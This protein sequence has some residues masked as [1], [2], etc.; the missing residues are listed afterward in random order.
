MNDARPISGTLPSLHHIHHSAYRCRDAE[1]TRWFYEDVLGLPLAAA[2]KLDRDEADGVYAEYMH[3]FFEMGDG[4]FI[5]FFDEP[6]H[7]SSDD[8]EKKH[9]F[10]LHIAFE[11]PSEI[12]LQTWR[13]RLERA[14]VK[15]ATIDHVFLRSIYFYDPNGIRLEIT[16]KTPKYEPVMAEERANARA[17]IADWTKSSRELKEQRFGAGAVDQRNHLTPDLPSLVAA[18]E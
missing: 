16:W 11:A 18:A 7:A 3:I 10:D 2:V 6:L 12:A 15:F 4:N 5:A 1:Q 9:G 8:F 17:Q 13:D 14:G